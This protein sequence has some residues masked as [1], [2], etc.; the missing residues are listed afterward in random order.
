MVLKLIGLGF[1]NYFNDRY[2]DFDCLIVVYSV[3]EIIVSTTALTDS[4]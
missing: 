1:K 2:N 3:C 4:E